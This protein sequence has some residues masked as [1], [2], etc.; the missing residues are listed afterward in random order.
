MRELHCKPTSRREPVSLPD[1]TAR[2]QNSERSWETAQTFVIETLNASG[3]PL[4]KPARS[5]FEPRFGHDLSRVRIYSDAKAAQSA[6]TLNADAYTV[7]S[8]VVF[9][10][11]RYFPETDAGRRLLTHELHHVIENEKQGRTNRIQRKVETHNVSIDDYLTGKGIENFEKRKSAYFHL[12]ICE[13]DREKE[14]LYD[15]LSSDRNFPVAGTTPATAQN[16]VGKQVKARK[17]IVEHTS[18]GSYRWGV[19]S[20][21]KM[22]PRYWQKK[23]DRW[24]AKPG[25]SLEEAS[26]DVFDNPSGFDYAMACHLATGVTFVAGSGSASYKESNTNE[27]DWVPGDWGYIENKAY[28]EGQSR[29]GTEGENIIYIGGR[30]FWGHPSGNKTF[31]EWMCYIQKMNNNTGKPE[32]KKWRKYTALGLD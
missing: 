17:G 25:V 30:Q 24:G 26:R 20:S 23:D 32:L 27:D 15:L 7:G 6:H 13:V 4:D 2:K 14:I 28:K 5:F 1:T 21:I 3:R 8:H 18:K 10:K 16:N 19:N 31:N 12:G 11:N 22:N 29:P 9:G